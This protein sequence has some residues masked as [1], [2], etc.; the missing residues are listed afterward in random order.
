M[1]LDDVRRIQKKDV[2]MTI[3]TTKEKSVWMKNNNISPSLLF[4]KAIEELMDK[5][6]KDNKK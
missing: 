5:V 1:E 6:E 4:D 2:I 3:R